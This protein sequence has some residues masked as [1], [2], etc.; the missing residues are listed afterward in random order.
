MPFAFRV[1][2]V[3]EAAL[4]VLFTSTTHGSEADPQVFPALHSCAGFASGQA[5]LLPFDWALESL[6][7]ERT[8]NK[9]TPE[10]CTTHRLISIAT[11]QD[12]VYTHATRVAA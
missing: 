3:A 2:A 12:S 6:V 5:F 7:S 11:S 1:M 4:E 8:D 10:P 9:T